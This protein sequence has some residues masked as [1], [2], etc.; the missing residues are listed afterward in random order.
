[1]GLVTKD[2]RATMLAAIAGGVVAATLSCA[3]T[4]QAPPGMTVVASSGTTSTPGSMLVAYPKT[5]CTGTDSA[6]FLDEK[7][8]FIGAVAP[9]TAT[10]VAFPA[11]ATKLW[12]V[13]SRDVVANPG[14][15]FRRH[16]VRAPGD[17]V[18]QGIL[19]EVARRDAKNCFRTAKPHPERVTYDVATQAA[20]P[21][22]WLD[23]RGDEDGEHWLAEHHARVT[24]LLGQPPADPAGGE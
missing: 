21:L 17:R 5:A 16:E 1:M 4:P 19:V 14:A 11:G 6:V 10:Y 20:L 15:W 13:S 9:G 3:S 22:V 24:E 2:V 8:A 12:M 7:G 18:E 23:V